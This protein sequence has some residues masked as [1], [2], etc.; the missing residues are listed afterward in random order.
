MIYECVCSTPCLSRDLNNGE[1]FAPL[2]II[3]AAVTM[4]VLRISM[5]RGVLS[6][7]YMSM[8][9]VRVLENNQASGNKELHT[10]KLFCPNEKHMSHVYVMYVYPQV[11]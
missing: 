1:G 2:Y 5:K 11:I 9:V 10:D 4:G 7:R 6:T 8:H 3:Y